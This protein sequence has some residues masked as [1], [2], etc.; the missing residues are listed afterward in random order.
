MAGLR[1]KNPGQQG[2]PADA[3]VVSM[4]LVRWKNIV[5]RRGISDYVR[6]AGPATGRGGA[7]EQ[8]C[9]IATKNR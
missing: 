7:V 6:G 9:K 3:A 8:C 4:R 5:R 1:K 2:L